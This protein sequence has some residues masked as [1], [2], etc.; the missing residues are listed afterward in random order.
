MADIARYASSTQKVSVVGSAAVSD[1][2][3]G[4]KIAFDKNMAV[5]APLSDATDRGIVHFSVP[6]PVNLYTAKLKLTDIKVVMSPGT[7]TAT[8]NVVEVYFDDDRKVRAADLDKSKTFTIQAGDSEY[9]YGQGIGVA[10]EMKF[11]NR[12]GAVA[13]ISLCLTFKVV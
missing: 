4:T 2:N 7:T 9:E 12:N 5:V 13:I 6:A 3:T 10:F 8:L 11:P 1:S